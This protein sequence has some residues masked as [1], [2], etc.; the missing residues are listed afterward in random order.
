MLKAVIHLVDRGQAQ[1]L[2]CD[3]YHYQ[4]DSVA[5]DYHKV[6]KNHSLILIRHRITRSVLQHLCHWPSLGPMTPVK[7]DSHR[8]KR[9]L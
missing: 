7:L 6:L 5:V 1:A 4:N 2:T 3:Y 8:Q 9:S